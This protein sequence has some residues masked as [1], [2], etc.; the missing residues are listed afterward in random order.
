M[1]LLCDPLTSVKSRKPDKRATC[2][3]K[4]KVTDEHKKDLCLYAAEKMKRCNFMFE[5]AD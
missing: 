4:E 2:P 5:G 1:C 3:L